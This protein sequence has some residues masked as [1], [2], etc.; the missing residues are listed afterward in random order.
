MLKS[1][2]ARATEA[3]RRSQG[4][5]AKTKKQGDDALK[6][7]Q[8]TRAAEAVKTARLRELRLAKEAADKEAA[9]AKAAAAPVK[10]RVRA[11]AKAAPSSPEAE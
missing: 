8:K 5:F 3:R 6:E 4:L 7:G 9:V 10:K 1:D 2:E 11:A